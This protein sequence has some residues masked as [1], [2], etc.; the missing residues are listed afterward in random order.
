MCLLPEKNR[1]AGI[2]LLRTIAI[3]IMLVANSVP[4]ILVGIKPIVFRV[5]LS[6]AAPLFIFLSGYSF[7]LS[8]AGLKRSGYLLASALFVDVFIWKIFPFQTFDVLYLISF[9]CFI[10]ALVKK[11][12]AVTKVVISVAII[13]IYATS[14]VLLNYRFDNGE[15][16]LSDHK[17][18]GALSVPF[19]SIRRFLFDGWFP[20][21]PWA[22]LPLMGSVVAERK[23]FLFR[24]M[25]SFF[26]AITSAFV[27]VFVIFSLTTI[28]TPE[29]EGYVE[30][31][32]PPSAL[33]GI[34]IV[35]FISILLYLVDKLQYQSLFIRLF[36]VLGRK[37]LF[38]YILHCA[39][40]SFIAEQYI[41]PGSFAF[42]FVWSFGFII[43]C[44]TTALIVERFEKTQL[45]RSVPPFVLKVLGL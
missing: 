45:Y 2:D 29:R 12:G 22:A 11:F 19:V 30:L 32:Y 36:C 39:V 13:F 43:L 28:N 8:R 10:N 5:V 15:I 41:S 35:G 21:F 44:Y 7:A 17:S 37:S 20:V 1:I 38:V 23:E 9:A 26:Y 27:A 25:K 16:L 4:Y 40:L 34:L 42:L 33:Y 6:L 31:F 24:F 14:F 18:L 3:I